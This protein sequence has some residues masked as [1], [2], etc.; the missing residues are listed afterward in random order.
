VSG[1]GVATFA[2]TEEEALRHYRQQ[3]S[4][5]GDC[6]VRGCGKPAVVQLDRVQLC[7][8]HHAN[9]TTRAGANYSTDSNPVHEDVRPPE[10]RPVR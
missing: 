8:Q 9:V 2:A 3:V 4:T 10:R 7:S 6:Q 5:L 1:H